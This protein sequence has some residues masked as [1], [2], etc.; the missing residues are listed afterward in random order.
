VFNLF[1]AADVV[2]VPSHAEYTE[3]FPLTM[4]EAIGSRTP[5]ICSD[6]PMF[7][8]VLR[9]CVHAAIFPA[10]DAG[11]F[12][13]T[14]ARLLTDG[15]LYAQLSANAELSWAAL[16]GP[17]DWRTMLT[18]WILEGR[19]SEWIQEHKLDGAQSGHG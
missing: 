16:K 17:A 4:F 11:A 15:D 19:E 18:K 14:I 6:H 5:I 10:G 12:A 1:R 8:P 13:R 9:D 7:V 2:A 3:G